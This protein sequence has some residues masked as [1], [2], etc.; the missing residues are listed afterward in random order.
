MHRKSFHARTAIVG[1]LSAIAALTVL[2]RNALTVKASEPKTT[3]QKARH[4][5]VGMWVTIHR[6][7]VL[8]VERQC[9]AA[10]GG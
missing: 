10:E 1:C 2:Q 7:P 4:T 5:Y 3:E 6:P 9:N 8:G